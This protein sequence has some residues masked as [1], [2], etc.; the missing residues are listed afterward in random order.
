MVFLS[1]E[2]GSK[3][4]RLYD[5]IGGKVVVSRD[6]VFDEAAASNWDG[7]EAEEGQGIS[8]TF[9]VEH[10]VI[11]GRPSAE[12]ELGGAEAGRSTD[13]A[14]ARSSES[15]RVTVARSLEL[16]ELGRAN[17][18]VSWWRGRSNWQS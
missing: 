7:P 6:V 15:P 4:C 14:E 3:A 12:A 17:H 18:H 11:H 8:T 1:Y 13:L 2:E 16:A 10:L 5:P 9:S